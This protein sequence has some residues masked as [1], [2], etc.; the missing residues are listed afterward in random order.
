[1]QLSRRQITDTEDNLCYIHTD[2]LGS[3]VRMTGEDGNVVMSLAYDP[4][5]KTV[6]S[7]GTE[8]ISYQY[9]GQELDPETGLYYY[10]ARYYDPELGRFNTWLNQ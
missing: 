4:Y 9:T 3:A 7:Y 8:E 10:G 1:M 5:G 6:Y 2:H